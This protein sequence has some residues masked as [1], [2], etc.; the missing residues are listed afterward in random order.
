MLALSV[1]LVV[2]SMLHEDLP[3]VCQNIPGIEKSD[4]KPYKSDPGNVN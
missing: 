4:E 1:V 3:V 2:C